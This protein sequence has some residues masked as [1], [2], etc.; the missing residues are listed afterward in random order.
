MKPSHFHPDRVVRRLLRGSSLPRW[1]RRIVQ[2]AVVVLAWASII[3]S[4]LSIASSARW[5][6][7]ASASVY[8]FAS[9]NLPLVLGLFDLLHHGIELWRSVTQP[10]FDILFGW[11]PFEVPRVALD[12]LIIVG[13]VVGGAARGWLA[14]IEE[15]RFM[16][17]IS[18]K[19][20]DTGRVAVLTRV[21][22]SI[23]MLDRARGMADREAG[24]T[25]A[26][27]GEAELV[28]ALDDLTDGAGT[29][30]GDD[31]II[32]EIMHWERHNAQEMLDYA[33]NVKAIELEI[34]RSILRRS[35]FVAALLVAVIVTDAV[36]LWLM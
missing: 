19:L 4:T 20:S 3:G 30:S 10:I 8:Q 13:V 34:R 25:L 36:Y 6:I 35:A 1:A 23:D 14:T 33:A 5:V 9:A 29:S 2:W 24:E 15:R 32:D 22:A 27:R 21:Y 28:S 18:P 26:D 12:M 17:A 16:R 7:D 11:V 31:K